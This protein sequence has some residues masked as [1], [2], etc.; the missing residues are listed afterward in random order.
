M[1]GMRQ[2]R[3]LCLRVHPDIP[4]DPADRL[5]AKAETAISSS[6]TAHDSH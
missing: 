2:G 1:D 4:E 5:G 3:W 6:M